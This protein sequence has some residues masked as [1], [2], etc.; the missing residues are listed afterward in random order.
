MG[1]ARA[2]VPV[3]AGRM[4][5][6]L[7]VVWSAGSLF[8]SLSFLWTP[9]GTIGI[10][11]NYGGG[12]ASVDPGSPADNAHIVAGDRIVLSV[13]P[14]DARPKLVG[15]T[16]PFAPGTVL[17]FAVRHGTFVRVLK[18]RA[19]VQHESAA[20]RVS[21]LFSSLSAAVSIVVGAGLI[22]L[23]PSLV[24]WGFGLFCLLC[25][26]IV[27]ALSQFP[28]ARAHLVY[29]TIYDV[30]QNV[31][32]IGLFVFALNFPRPLRLHWRAEFV[33]GLR[34]IFA[35]LA[36]WTL[37]IDYAVC[38]FAIP[39]RQDNVGLQLVF[40][41]VDAIT[42]LLVSETYVKGPPENRP[43]LR[44]VLV[45]FYVGL[46][47]NYI[48]NTLLYTA[49]VSLPDWVDTLLVASQVTLPLAVSYAIVRHR[50]I[51]I[52][53]FF[54]RALVF[55]AFTTLLALIFGITDWI[56]GLVLED[57]R[58]SIVFNAGIS[59]GIAFLFDR[60]RKML[61]NV[62]SRIVF[63]V[64]QIAYDRL[65]RT[66]ST[67]R[68]IEDLSALDQAVVREPHDAL[69]ITSVML[70][71]R[72][73]DAYHLAA[74]AGLAEQPPV[75]L[76]R[77]DRLIL[78]HMAREGALLLAEIPWHRDDLP[79]DLERPVLSIPLRSAADV[80]GLLLCS[81]KRNGEDID[82]EE[83]NHIKQF[84]SSA[85]VAYD[86]LR[87]EEIRREAEEL[88]MQVTTL[89]ARLEEARRESRRAA[90]DKAGL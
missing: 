59:V 54:S 77:D 64:R 71:R 44:W 43:R 17:R 40:G 90:M 42:I 50:V 73:G 89:S 57:F 9:R 34:L 25:N 22:F 38:V 1:T 80:A 41:A 56:F 27:P 8:V 47:C 26:P 68:F 48:G 74:N 33:H 14:F 52:D 31:G 19:I 62:A 39:V 11:A 7:L 24:T 75:T 20:D 45:G 36:L 35:L 51:E 37:W 28:S 18:L 6:A 63:H 32:V 16:T 84:T 85:A 55:A 5:L 83:L 10:H 67:F 12:I 58:L 66:S 61:E 15:T 69:G 4:L 46:I 2:T 30:V 13:T 49:N 65:K 78:E 29:V 86:R 81:R 23:R 70:F 79:T 88:R 21:M 72:D 82:P 60:L 76:S 87:A 53:L 3:I